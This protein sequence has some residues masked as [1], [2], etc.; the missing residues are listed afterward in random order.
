MLLIYYF[1]S[2]SFFL[3]TIGVNDY[4]LTYWVTYD[5]KSP[6]TGRVNKHFL[7]FYSFPVHN[8]VRV[9]FP[10]FSLSLSISFY[11]KIVNCQSFLLPVRPPWPWRVWGWR[12]RWCRWCWRWWSRPSPLCHHCWLLGLLPHLTNSTNIF[13]LVLKNKISTSHS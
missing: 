6:Y 11:S 7:H 3:L 10:F 2:V 12:T 13:V 1:A 8:D 9:F 4:W 5:R